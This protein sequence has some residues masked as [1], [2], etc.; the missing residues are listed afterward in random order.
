MV[1]EYSELVVPLTDFTVCNDM[2]AIKEQSG[3]ANISGSLE[4]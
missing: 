1:N 2:K 4:A 3:N